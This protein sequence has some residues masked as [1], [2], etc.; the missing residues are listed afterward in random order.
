MSSIGDQIAIFG[1][2]SG[3]AAGMLTA[4]AKYGKARELIY[5][6][7]RDLEHAKN[8]AAQANKALIEL[9]IQVN[10]LE[11]DLVEIRTIVQ[12]LL[13]ERGQTTSEILGYKVRGINANRSG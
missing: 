9:D 2:V 6:N 5:A 7:K 11:N 12:M 4:I 3:I 13:A 8:N 10:L 1:F